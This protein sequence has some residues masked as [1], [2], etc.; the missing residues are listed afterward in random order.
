MFNSHPVVRF[1]LNLSKE[2]AEDDNMC[3]KFSMY[4]SNE[5]ASN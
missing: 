3:T 2:R 1:N 4:D 5:G